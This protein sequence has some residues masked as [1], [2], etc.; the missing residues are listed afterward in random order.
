MK[1]RHFYL[2]L[3]I[4]F[5]SSV[6]WAESSA[7]GSI[8]VNAKVLEKVSITVPAAIDFGNIGRGETT[9]GTPVT[10]TFGLS[11]EGGALLNITVTNS[12][13]VRTGATL[14]AVAAD[15]L[16]VTFAMGTP[17]TGQNTV[18][19]VVT[20]TVTLS[21]TFNP[22]PT[23]ATGTANVIVSARR[24]GVPIGQNKGSYVGSIAVLARY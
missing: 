12:A 21:G 23:S 4:F 22:S 9:V 15:I 20:G 6:G 5:V 11:G 16:P 24:D 17:L 2:V 19:N 7:N 8:N 10:A 1:S 3:M 14:P 13:P 18:G